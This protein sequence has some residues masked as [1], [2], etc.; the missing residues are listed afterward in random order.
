MKFVEF[1]SSGANLAAENFRG[2][3]RLAVCEDGKWAE[4]YNLSV[5]EYPAAV[6]DFFAESGELKI[7]GDD[8]DV[9]CAGEK[10]GYVYEV[11]DGYITGVYDGDFYF[12]GKRI[13]YYGPLEEDFTIRSGDRIEMAKIGKRYVILAVGENN[14]RIWTYTPDGTSFGT[15]E[16]REGDGYLKT[17]ILENVIEDGFLFLLTPSSP[18]TNCRVNR[19]ERAS[20][21]RYYCFMPYEAQTM[22]DSRKYSSHIK[23]LRKVEEY[24]GHYGTVLYLRAAADNLNP[25][26]YCFD[27]FDSE[28]PVR[29]VVDAAGTKG[30]GGEISAIEQLWEM[31]NAEYDEIYDVSG[32]N[33]PIQCYAPYRASTAAE[34]KV[35]KYDYDTAE[36][37]GEYSF[38]DGSYRENSCGIIGH[39]E[40]WDEEKARY[41]FWDGYE[42]SN[43][44]GSM[45]YGT[46]DDEGNE[47]TSCSVSAKV[48]KSRTAIPV[49]VIG[50]MNEAVKLSHMTVYGGRVCAAVGDGSQ[51]MF[52]ASGQYTKFG[53]FSSGAAGSGFTESIAG[54]EFTGMCEYAGYLV[55]FTREK[56]LL[57]YGTTPSDT[58]LVRTVKKGCTDGRSIREA[59]GVLYFLSE[60]G[61]YMFGGGQ[62]QRISR[63]L[64]RKYTK[65][66]A[67]GNGD[68]YTVIAESA[69]GRE[70]LEYDAAADAWSEKSAPEG[71]FICAAEGGAVTTAGKIYKR[72]DGGVWKLESGDMVSGGV[73]DKG[74][75]EVYIR[76]RFC[77][78]MSVYTITDGVKYAH[79]TVK[80]DGEKI[81]VHRIPVRLKHKSYYRIG[82]EGEGAATLYRAEWRT[83]EG[84]RK[85]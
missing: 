79:K 40:K 73:D 48:Y 70:V 62:P 60:D 12:E 18:D 43:G 38:A 3:S 45:V 34:L 23:K 55:M 32:L 17:D 24:I 69:E 85:R 54:G 49:T 53:D 56:M 75:N 35:K 61:F 26:R 50:M 11:K 57:Y 2:L 42:G 28:H 25:E 78:S 27:D 4:F 65:A 52:S 9:L 51:I 19:I 36:Y 37:T 31:E 1:D 72:T 63:G 5:E 16:E 6:T 30:A 20:G 67:F 10:I 47:L 64:K 8:G 66:A 14:S 82:I 68:R 59:G 21:K 33:N 84:G 77:G 71:E 46:V 74:V 58:S 41:D 7:K 81:E 80:S 22:S 13:E 29:F 83:Y 44:C 15:A 39:F 76:A